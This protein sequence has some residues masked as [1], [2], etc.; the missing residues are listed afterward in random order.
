MLYSRINI[1]RSWLII[2]FVTRSTRRVSLVE[3]E[4]LTILKL[5]SSPP[6]FSGVRMTRSLVLYICFVD[7]CFFLCFLFWPLWCLFFLDIHI[8]NLQTLHILYRYLYWFLV[9]CLATSESYFSN[10]YS[11]KRIWVHPRFFVG[12]RVAQ[13]LSF[14]CCPIMCLYVM[15]SVLW[16]PLRFPHKNDVRFV[17][18][19]SCL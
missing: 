7:R 3:Q 6:V 13:L 11:N 8:L 10:S 4:L 5:L 2:G 15:G 16:C 1:Y 12:I 17:F 18:T 19:S 9:W 14:W